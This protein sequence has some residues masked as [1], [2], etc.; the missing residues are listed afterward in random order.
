MRRILT[1]S[2]RRPKRKDLFRVGLV[3]ERDTWL[4]VK[5]GVLKI[6]TQADM[7]KWIVVQLVALNRGGS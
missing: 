4:Y 7:E 5:A 1:K 3:Y 6:Q 2:M